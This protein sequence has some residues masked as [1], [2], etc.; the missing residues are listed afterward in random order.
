MHPK[1]QLMERG[2]S[3]ICEFLVDNSGQEVQKISVI[4][5]LPRLLEENGNECIQQ[6]L[7]R[8]KEIV[9]MPPVELQ[10]AASQSLISVLEK[11]LLPPSTYTESFLQSILTSVD[12]KDQV[13]ANAWLETLLDVI[14]LLPREVIQK[15]I[16]TLAISKGQISQPVESRLSCCKILG[17]ITTK[18]EP[19]LIKKEILP[20]VQSLCQDVDYEVRACMC[21]QLDSVARGIGLESTKNSIL[22]ELVELANDEEGAVRLAALETVVHLLSL[23]DDDT[24]IYII[25]PLVRKI[26][27][28]TLKAE[29][30]SLPVVARLLGKLC[31]GL[32]VNLN[33]EQKD[34]FL[35]YY[36]QLCQLGLTETGVKVKKVLDP[37]YQQVP[38]DPFLLF[39]DADVYADSRLSSA[40]NFPAFVLFVGVDSF[41]KTL[42]DTFAALCD[43][44]SPGVRK[45][46]AAGL[47]EIAKILGQDVKLIIPQFLALLKDE[48][49]DVME[50][51]I[52]NL[53]QTLECF[54]KSLRNGRTGVISTE[55]VLGDVCGM[56]LCSSLLYCEQAVSESINWRLHEELM[57]KLSSLTKC[58]SSDE[59]YSKFVPLCFHKASV[60][61][62][63]PVRR[64]AARTLCVFLRNNRK[65]QQREN[66]HDR[67]IDDFCHHASCHKRM[68]FIDFCGIVMEMFSRGYF[69]HNFLTYLLELH[70]DAVPNIRLRLC[71]N[72]PKLKSIMYL[73]EDRAYLQLLESCVR[74]LMI[75]ET[76]RDVTDAVRKAIIELDQIEVP[77]KSITKRKFLDEDVE[78]RKKEDEEKLLLTLEAKQMHDEQNKKFDHK[79]SNMKPGKIPVRKNIV[80][81][82]QIKDIKRLPC[83]GKLNKD[84]N[85]TNA[86]VNNNTK[87]QLAVTQPPSPRPMIRSRSREQM[88]KTT[89]SRIP[90]PAVISRQPLSSNGIASRPHTGTPATSPTSEYPLREGSPIPMLFKQKDVVSHGNA[91]DGAHSHMNGNMTSPAKTTNSHI[92]TMIRC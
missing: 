44:P 1:K 64:A 47:H 10:V 6:V 74:A 19:Y 91:N 7:P 38:E 29:D 75:N 89:G 78:D 13:V 55:S 14:D 36:K 2:G 68:L 77:M 54:S 9:C 25:I 83:K 85:V 16:L 33:Q 22:P 67:I 56:E 73:P 26:C 87:Q 60:S 80:N 27:E 23:L 46:I 57:T 72:L 61:R 81:I 3:S 51:I 76:D 50:G 12:S 11:E 53:S 43:D 37:R 84:N 34:W 90:S 79:P 21:K 18:F 28:I 69:K 63:L 65:L 49:I 52:P 40:Y 41:S 86:K 66:I 42:Y 58:L 35:Q 5:N 31:H 39:D 82:P 62:A 30:C 88:N 92:P 32:S 24:C 4:E 20:I 45:S 71:N 59:I 15:E 8:V 17:K 48:Y 70:Q